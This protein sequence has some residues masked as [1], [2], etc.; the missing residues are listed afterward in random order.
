MI[1]DNFANPVTAYLRG[2]E[3]KPIKPGSVDH[4]ILK[5]NAMSNPGSMRIVPKEEVMSHTQGPWSVVRFADETVSIIIG[6][7]EMSVSVKCTETKN[8][9]LELMQMRA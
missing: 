7:G 4:G 5:L 1:D 8:Q 2:R 3:K 6:P 9:N